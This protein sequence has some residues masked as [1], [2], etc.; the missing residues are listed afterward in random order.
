MLLK[1]RAPDPLLLPPLCR[2]TRS[3]AISQQALAEERE[4]GEWEES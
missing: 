4:S 2:G 1:N 3:V